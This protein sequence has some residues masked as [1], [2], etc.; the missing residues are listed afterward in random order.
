MVKKC[1]IVFLLINLIIWTGSCASWSKTKKGAAYGAG[2]GAVLGGLVG[3][4]AGNTLMG[5]IL[6][7]AVGGAA[8]AY[9]GRYMDKQAAEM[10]RELEDAKVQRIEEAIRINFDSGLLF[11]VN[12]ADIRAEGK[13]NLEKLA[14][15]LNKYADTNILIEGHTDS[16]GSAEHNLALSKRRAESV[17]HYLA[18]LGVKVSRF[19]LMGYG[20]EQ[21][22]AG[23]DTPEGRQANRRV[24]VAVIAN[25][26]LKKAAESQG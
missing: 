23:N 25:E 24:D 6:G 17:G 3:K 11:D 18:G 26:A 14:K 16:T 2:A 15:I 9:I 4:A 5:A 21:P 1:L 19:S 13:T 7:A 20:M 22:I 8:G 12:R 10:E